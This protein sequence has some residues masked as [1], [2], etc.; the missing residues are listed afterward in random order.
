[1]PKDTFSN[2]AAH[3]MKTAETSYT[4]P[5]Q[6]VS[7]QSDKYFIYTYFIFSA[8]NCTVPV[9]HNGKVTLQDG[10]EVTDDVAAG[11]VV[12]FR[13]DIGFTL[14]GQSELACDSSGKLNDTAPYCTGMY[15]RNK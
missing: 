3:L 5:L 6:T 11:S 15:K 1:M 7:I 10:R 14:Y 12:T 9:L 2:G 8:L 4:L 13:C